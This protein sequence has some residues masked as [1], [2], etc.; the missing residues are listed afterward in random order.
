M[1]C[2]LLGVLAVALIIVAIAVLYVYIAFPNDVHDE[3]IREISKNGKKV[4]LTKRC[5][6][7]TVGCYFVLYEGE[8][9]PSAI[10][11]VLKDFGVMPN[12]TCDDKGRT[13]VRVDSRDSIVSLIGNASVEDADTGG[14]LIRLQ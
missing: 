7:A 2:F 10:A 3:V 13:V 8:I 12:V 9:N 11:L 4:V 5:G 14:V 6:G 1:K